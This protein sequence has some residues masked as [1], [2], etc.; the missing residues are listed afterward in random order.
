MDTLTDPILLANIAYLFLA[1]GVGLMVLAVFSPGTGILEGIALICLLLA[2]LGMYMLPV[3][4]WALLIVLV[5]LVFLIISLRR[6]SN[7]PQYLIISFVLII[8]G[9]AFMFRSENWWVPAV[10]PFLATTVSLLSGGFFWI[11]SRKYMEVLEIRPSHDLE[12]LIGERGEAKTDIRE[13]GSVH[14]A[15]ELWTAFSKKPI[16]AGAPVRV[17]NRRGFAL[18]V[19][20]IHDNIPEEETD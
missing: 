1:A 19:E 16:T 2:G 15:G 12:G 10:N 18:E 4:W 6:T 20:A 5:G 8:L 7:L 17:L 11:A 9:S 3:N 14:V 13:D